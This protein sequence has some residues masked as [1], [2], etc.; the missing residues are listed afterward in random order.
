MTARLALASLF[1]VPAAMAYPW[2]STADRWLLGIAIAAVIVLLAWWR[3]A[4]FTTVVGRRLAIWRRNHSTHVEKPSPY[5]TVL[6]RVDSPELEELPLP[7]IA[8]YVDRYGLRCDK[9]RVTGRR[10][11][12]E[13]STWI[14]LTV[15]AAD[16]LA[17]LRARSPQIPLRDT[18]EV[19][20]RRLADHLRETGCDV[21]IVDTADVPAPAGKETWRGV[22]DEKGYVAAYGVAVDDR[23]TQTL[24][25][26]WAYPSR[27]AWIA[28]EF[29][30]RA[31]H[32]AMA[33]ACAL[34]TDDRP[35]ATAPVSGLTPY[36]GRHRPVLE[37]LRPLSVARLDG[38]P[39]PL[40][41]GLL[42]RLN[43]PATQASSPRIPA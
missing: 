32:L 4:F 35:G 19:A 28:V 33:A 5:T 37:A 24:A 26:A 43:W 3:G 17:A 12:D 7:L 14:S 18:A 8:G 20:A 16:N 40:P 13:S 21:A 22:R 9:V 34:R 6:L 1:I 29:T 11:A 2:P 36:R 42:D 38:V 41:D 23:L 15:G 31:A 30:G 39:V 25:D 27:E 10:T